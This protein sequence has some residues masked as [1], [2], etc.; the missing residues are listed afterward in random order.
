MSVGI[1]I[2][3]LSGSGRTSIF[4]AITRGKAE[5]GGFGGGTANIGIAKVPDERLRVLTGMFHPKKTIPAEIK[6]LDLGASVK[7]MTIGGPLLQQLATVDALLNVVRAFNDP[8]VPHPAGSID[9]ARDISGMNLEL[10][11]SDLAIIERRFD[12]I[13]SSLKGAKPEE[14]IRLLQEK[15]LLIRIR[16]ELEKDIPLREQTLTEEEWRII[17][18]Y[19]FLSAKPIITA[20]NIGE[21]DLPSANDMAAQLNQ[22]FGQPNHRLIVLCGKLEMDL[23]GLDEA[24]TTE[25]LSGYGLEKTGL[26]RV[27]Q[28]SFELLGLISFLTVGEDEVRAWPIQHDTPAQKAAGKVHSDIERGFI[29]AEVVS[30]KDLIDCGSLAEARKRGLLRLEGK[31]YIVNDGDIINFLFNV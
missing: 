30:Y 1:G 14:R 23:A 18:G 25:F 17:S 13:G 26:E 2:I 16:G 9:V 3:G 28:T 6:Y 22:Q 20:V 8:I 7:S 12:R 27:I 4:N 10:A 5:T 19:Q 21:E 29:R 31:I 15:D 11:F 24:S